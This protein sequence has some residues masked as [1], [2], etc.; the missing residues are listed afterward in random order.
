[1]Q[2]QS[3]GGRCS[4]HVPLVRC[5]AN[6]WDFSLTRGTR[7]AFCELLLQTCL[8]PILLVCDEVAAQVRFALGPDLNVQYTTARVLSHEL[9]ET[10]ATEMKDVRPGG[11]GKV[12]RPMRA[13][14]RLSQTASGP[15]QA[16][17]DPASS[18]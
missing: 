11:E 6:C 9:R 15:S 5:T 16:M 18:R 8:A 12:Q 17:D 10:M 2:A 13:R 14:A 3:G 1:M 4:N 7:Q